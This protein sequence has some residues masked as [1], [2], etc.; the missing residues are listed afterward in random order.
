MIASRFQLDIDDVTGVSLSLSLSISL[1]TTSQEKSPTHNIPG[2]LAPDII[3]STEAIPIL[4]VRRAQWARE[5]EREREWDGSDVTL[6]ALNWRWILHLSVNST[7]VQAHAPTVGPPLHSWGP[8]KLRQRQS[9]RFVLFEQRDSGLRA[10]LPGIRLISLGLEKPAWLF[11]SPYWPRLCLGQYVGSE[12]NR[13][14]FL[15]LGK[16]KVYL[17][18]MSR[19]CKG[20][21]WEGCGMWGFYSLTSKALWKK[22]GQNWSWA[23]VW[24]NA[25]TCVKLCIWAALYARFN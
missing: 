10:N 5:R 15:G 1:S 16:F 2:A 4:C 25:S 7:G 8:Q 13:R 14:Y 9:F 19:Q 20:I 11:S 22:E 12:N 17:W 6:V 24:K 21:D 23:R 3:G 18:M